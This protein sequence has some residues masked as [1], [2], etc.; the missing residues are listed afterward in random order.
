MPLSQSL[1]VQELGFARLVPSGHGAA[2]IDQMLSPGEILALYK[3]IFAHPV[4]SLDVGSGDPLAMMLR[5]AG[6]PQDEDADPFPG[7]AAPPGFR[8]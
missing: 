1:G 4:S 6:V 8:D 7:E 2:L 3:K 5:L